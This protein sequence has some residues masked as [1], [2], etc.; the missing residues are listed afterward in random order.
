MQYKHLP[1]VETRFSLKIAIQQRFQFK[2]W[3]NPPRVLGSHLAWALG[4][5]LR[6]ERFNRAEITNWYR[7]IDRMMIGRV[8]NYLLPK[9]K[10]GNTCTRAIYELVKSV[11]FTTSGNTKT[12][13]R[14]TLMPCRCPR[15]A[16]QRSSTLQRQW[17]LDLNRPDEME[18]SGFPICWEIGCC[19]GLFHDDQLSL[20]YA[21]VEGTS[22]L[23]CIVCVGLGYKN[24]KCLTSFIVF[25]EKFDEYGH[26]FWENLLN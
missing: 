2:T 7:H 25:Q 26:P 5:Q 24:G 10:H 14:C 15:D 21:W 16:Q 8:W 23:P 4:Q 6:R 17:G 12:K 13:F 20:Q 3:D 9:S 18:L 19:H 11:S 1:H 22:S